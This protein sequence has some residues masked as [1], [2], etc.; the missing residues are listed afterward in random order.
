MVED[1]VVLVRGGTSEYITSLA[2][3]ELPT[4]ELMQEWGAAVQ[5]NPAII[6]IKAEPL[7]ELVTATDFAYSSTVKQNI[8]KA[9]EEF[10]MEISSCHC[11]PCQ[12][13][14]VPVLK[15]SRCDCIC[16]A[17]FQGIACEVTNRKDTPIDGQWS[18]W[19][20]WSS[21][22]G[23]QKRRQRQ[24]NNPPPQKGGS[25]C[26]GPDSETLNC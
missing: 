24:C 13:N 3:K 16:P 18:C 7:Y 15:G 21:C 11:A 17:G 22:S 26:S 6:K 5:Y 20:N 10:Q 1:L 2:Y 4:A 8:Q 19:S 14:G 12:G 23:G 9:L 25:L